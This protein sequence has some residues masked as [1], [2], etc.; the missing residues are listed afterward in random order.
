[1]LSDKVNLVIEIPNLNEAVNI[2]HRVNSLEKILLLIM[3]K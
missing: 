1:M 3:G 2:S